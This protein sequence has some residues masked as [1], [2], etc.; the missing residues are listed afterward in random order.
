MSSIM[1]LDGDGAQM[2]YDDRWLPILDALG[3]FTVTR[4][5]RVEYDHAT[6]DWIATHINSGQEIARGRNR[7]EVIQAEVAWL[8]EHQIGRTCNVTHDKNQGRIQGP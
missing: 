4:A 2:V 6:R 3:P 8:E 5:T 7:S 1:I